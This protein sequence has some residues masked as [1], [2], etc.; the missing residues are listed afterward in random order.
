[1][2]RHSF[3]IMIEDDSS[4]PG[5]DLISESI[6]RSRKESADL[7]NATRAL[8]SVGFLFLY[9]VGIIVFDM[10]MFRSTLL[11]VAI[12]CVGAACL[13]FFGKRKPALLHL[14]RYAVPLF[15][16][17]AVFWIQWINIPAAESA[18]ATSIFT[19]SIY[20]FLTVMSNFAMRQRQLLACAVIGTVCMWILSERADLPSISFLSA[21][22][23]LAITAWMM[24]H[25]SLRQIRLIREG[26]ERQAKRDRL[27]RYFSPG[28]AEVIE[29]HDEPGAGEACELSVLFCD[30]RGFTS[31]SEHL[32]APVVV[33]LLNEF[34]GRMVDEVFRTGGTLDK[35]LGDGLLAWFNAPVRQSDHAERAVTCA[36]A[37]KDALSDLN[38]SR[39]GEGI[40]PIC[41]GIGIHCGQA[42]VGNIG[43]AHRREFTAIGDTVNVASRLQGLTR[44]HAVEVLVSEAV[45]E[46]V[47]D[48]LGVTFDAVGEVEVRGREKAVK[49]FVPERK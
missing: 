3:A 45:R 31:L 5:S 26:A 25:L 42:I 34:F 28:V 20:V 49:V 36:L 29:S 4:S 46:Q 33:T 7:L 8:L 21:P 39:K 30:I 12:Y 22:L 35:Y 18:E 44:K 11:L 41:F 32:P 23:I 2:N 38:E 6:E 24:G 17:P 47:P 16:M 37:M 13:W 15:D 9:L 27:A 43:A 48:E 19:L 1:M 40:E 14:S 10:E